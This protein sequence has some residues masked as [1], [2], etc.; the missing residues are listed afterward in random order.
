MVLG[1]N[2]H[3]CQ[4]RPS[5]GRFSS[6]HIHRIRIKISKSPELDIKADAVGGS[7]KLDTRAR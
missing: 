5:E 1:Q 2:S 7:L 6:S 3:E 4:P